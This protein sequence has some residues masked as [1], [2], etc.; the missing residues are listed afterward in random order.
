VLESGQRTDLLARYVR[1]KQHN[2]GVFRRVVTPA[3]RRPGQA[4][5]VLE[6]GHR[7]GR[8][9]VRPQPHNQPAQRR[10][11]LYCRAGLPLS[12]PP[13]CS[14]LIAALTGAAWRPT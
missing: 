3:Y 5:E 1:V 4:W 10:R 7:I 14:V 2:R 6:C 9:W 8:P 11:C 12:W 13:L